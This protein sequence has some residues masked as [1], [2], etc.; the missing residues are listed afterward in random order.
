MFGED[1]NSGNDLKPWFDFECREK[2]GKLRQALRIFTKGN[3]E[4]EASEL[5]N[6]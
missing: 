3:I 2:R 6:I 4:V 1:I 5:I